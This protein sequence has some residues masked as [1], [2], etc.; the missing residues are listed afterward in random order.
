MAGDA[1]RGL[2]LRHTEARALELP[3]RNIQVNCI[4]PRWFETR[5]TRIIAVQDIGKIV[6]SI[7]RQSRAALRANHPDR[8]R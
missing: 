2:R 8:R 5:S 1:L 7:L 6:T 3:A 4:A